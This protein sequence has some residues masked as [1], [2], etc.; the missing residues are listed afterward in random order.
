MKKITETERIKK[1][2]EEYKSNPTVAKNHTYTEYINQVTKERQNLYK[3]IILSKFKKS[4]ELELLEVGAGSGSNLASFKNLGLLDKNIYANELL[5]DRVKDLKTNSPNVNILPGD[6]LQLS[7]ENKFDIVFQS[8]VFTSILN[9]D[10]KKQFANKLWN[11]T[12]QNGIILWYDF[13]YDNPKNKSVKGINKSEI[14]LLFK[15]STKI[16]FHKV[17]LAPPIGRRFQK[18]Y[19]LL[20]SFSF[21]RTHIVAVIHK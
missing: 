20:N 12:K 10:F 18:L 4:E 19:S 3:Q 6:A 8:T 14:K 9:A 21:L 7:Y 13:I 2:Y 5:E 15:D 11:M 17:T 16:E 1:N